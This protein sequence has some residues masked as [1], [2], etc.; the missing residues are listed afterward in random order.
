MRWR[1]EVEVDSGRVRFASRLFRTGRAP[2]PG[3]ATFA[4]TMLGAR[5]ARY[6]IGDVSRASA[7]HTPP[8]SQLGFASGDIPPLLST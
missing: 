3:V 4:V 1:N 7:V 8:A 2:T 5:R 6:R